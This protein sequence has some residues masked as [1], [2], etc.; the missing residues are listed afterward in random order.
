MIHYVSLALFFFLNLIFGNLNILNDHISKFLKSFVL[1]TQGVFHEDT[2]FIL[3]LVL[4]F[5]LYNIQT[6]HVKHVVHDLFYKTPMPPT[7]LKNKIE[8]K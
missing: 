8:K 7:I 1:A 3:K 6:K 2:N 4:P 5:L